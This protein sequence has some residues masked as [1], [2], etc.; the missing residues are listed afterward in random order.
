MRR[1]DKSMINQATVTTKE[2]A[3]LLLA[4]DGTNQD[5]LARKNATSRLREVQKLG[6]FMAGLVE[7]WG[8]APNEIL[9]HLGIIQ[10]KNNTRWFFSKKAAE[11]IANIEV[12]R[13][14]VR[15]KL[16]EGF[17]KEDNYNMAQQAAAALA[18][19]A[20][21]DWMKKNTSI[22]TRSCEMMT[23]EQW[24][25]KG[26]LLSYEVLNEIASIRLASQQAGFNSIAEKTIAVL[27]PIW[28][29]AC[30]TS[31]Q[32]ITMLSESKCSTDDVLTQLTLLKFT[33]GSLQKLLISAPR[34]I[35]SSDA[36][37]QFVGNITDLLEFFGLQCYGSIPDE[38]AQLSSIKER[39][40]EILVDA[41]T[42]V[43]ELAQKNPIFF[44][45]LLK[46][47]LEFAMK[48]I[49]DDDNPP[50]MLS[51][52]FNFLSKIW[53]K[54][55]SSHHNG[56]N[57]KRGKHN[58]GEMSQAKSEA[59]QIVQ[60]F[61]SD[62]NIVQLTQL[63][64]QKFLILKKKDMEKWNEDPEDFFQDSLIEHS[65]V[66]VRQVCADFLK[67]LMKKR[68][69]IIGVQIVDWF[70]NSLQQ[71]INSEEVAVYRETIYHAVGLVYFDLHNPLKSIQFNI[72]QFYKEF[73]RKDVNPSGPKFLVR[74]AIWLIAEIKDDLLRRRDITIDAFA[75]ITEL[76]Q[77]H[78]DIVVR[79][80]CVRALSKLLEDSACDTSCFFPVASNACQ[81]LLQLLNNLSN[82]SNITFVINCLNHIL[83]KFGQD[84][85]EDAVILLQL[86][87]KLWD[88]FDH[89]LVRSSV[90]GVLTSVVKSLKSTSEK[91][92]EFLI[93]VLEY[94]TDFTQ[95]QRLY[96]TEAGLDLWLAVVQNSSKMTPQLM[97]L[98]KRWVLCME[99]FR[100]YNQQC[101][102]LLKSYLLLGQ[103]EFI[104]TYEQQIKG[105]LFSIAQTIDQQTMSSLAQILCLFIQIFP[106][107][108]PQ[109]LQPVLERIFVSFN[110]LTTPFATKL[111]KPYL[112]VFGRLF[113]ENF[114]GGAKLLHEFEQRESRQILNDFLK[115]YMAYAEKMR[116]PV[117]KKICIL[118]LANFAQHELSNDIFTRMI[119]ILFKCAVETKVSDHVEG[120]SR[121]PPRTEP[122]RQL[123]L[124][125]A[126]RSRQVDLL[127]HC[128]EATEMI[129]QKTGAQVFK[130]TLKKVP[131][132]ILDKF[133][134]HRSRR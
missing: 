72:S 90:V 70:Q 31:V 93:P 59:A 80:E 8:S 20:R 22:I 112:L 127:S 25:F 62:H 32:R 38:N 51:F 97:T 79:L 10:L 1:Q 81:G 124:V 7:I 131:D 110:E 15:S 28:K 42:C 13:M 39:I 47:Y 125:I 46:K 76:L 17:A 68:K 87:R 103:K 41:Q 14:Q 64:I 36:A 96:L 23:N 100:D 113:F 12:E 60:T 94:V 101:L 16:L 3:T 92:H 63:M 128:K 118:A 5:Q 54:H 99:R 65:T 61:F 75:V 45:P 33:N 133:H 111:I 30:E 123:Q 85:G 71:P 120:T 91:C 27:F 57:K 88:T 55:S 73:L 19:I 134:R 53:Q 122:E 121:G 130:R 18:K 6:G 105:A 34:N 74:R 35:K 108:S 95:A 40:G 104:S 56:K 44:R 48:V 132:H 82:V 24:R 11:D 102:E 2:V 98:F 50:I 66:G 69:G 52:A 107:N 26:C 67:K 78:Q 119:P 89:D 114:L 77:K 86:V 84:M 9:R 129:M 37:A 58:R 43:I 49:S 116:V 126:D 21:A 83:N 29:Q 4:A 109:F 115:R 117:E 106:E